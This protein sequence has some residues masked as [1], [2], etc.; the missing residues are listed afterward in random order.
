MELR[1][2]GSGP[3]ELGELSAGEDDEE[4]SGFKPLLRFGARRSS[5]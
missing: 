4:E 5:S 3:A 1:L 2:S